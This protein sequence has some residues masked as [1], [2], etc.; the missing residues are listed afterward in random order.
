MSALSNYLENQII[1]WLLRGQAFVPP[2]TLYI[3]LMTTAGTDVS[4]GIEVTGGGYARVA[5]DSTLLNWSGTQSASSQTV[6]S[7]T[8]GTTSNNVAIE[9]PIP[10]GDWGTVVEFGV[11]DASI[12]GNLL[13]RAALELPTTIYFGDTAPTFASNALSFQLDN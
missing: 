1:D 9:F 12:G 6:S 10:S 4:P 2:T 8:S 11:F 7:G 13:W 5:I 3:G